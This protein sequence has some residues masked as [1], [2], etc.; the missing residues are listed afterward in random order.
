M[1]ISL[2]AVP[3]CYIFNMYLTSICL[4]LAKA[5]GPF[6]ST[7]S[8]DKQLERLE[9]GNG[10]CLPSHSNLHTTFGIIALQVK[11]GETWFC[12]TSGSTVGSSSRNGSCSRSTE[13]VFPKV[14]IPGDWKLGLITQINQQVR[15]S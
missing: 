3:A 15:S 2:S 8:R 5:F 10:P 14:L 1:S 13:T 9:G 7:L 4:I 6:L 12:A 11:G